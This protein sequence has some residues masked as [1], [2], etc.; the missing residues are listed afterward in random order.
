MEDTR[1]PICPVCGHYY[2]D[3]G[4]K[5]LWSCAYGVY[6]PVAVYKHYAAGRQCTRQLCCIE[7]TE[8]M[9]PMLNPPG[10]P[11]PT[12]YKE[13]WSSSEDRQPQDYDLHGQPIAS[14]HG[15]YQGYLDN[16]NSVNDKVN[17]LAQQGSEIIAD[18]LYGE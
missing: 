15:W 4:L 11:S 12:Q 18:D 9:E 2:A 1:K 10:E 7:A 5:S 13:L 6:A 16:L 3:Y 14:A 17:K 8:L